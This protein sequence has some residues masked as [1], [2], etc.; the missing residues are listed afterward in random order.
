VRIAFIG[1]NHFANCARAL[2]EDGHDLTHFFSP[3]GRAAPSL[4]HLDDV[5]HRVR[6]KVRVGRVTRDDI[7]RAIN[8]G[9]EVLLSA[10]YPWRVPVDVDETI[11]A[12]N[13][14]PSPLPEGR[15]PA[16][17]EWAI[18]TGR[19]ATAVT[20]HQMLQ[21]F[22]AGP[23]LWQQPLA[24]APGE[25]VTSLR[26]RGAEL[27]ERGVR[28]V[29]G[30]F[31]RTW[32]ERQPQGPG[33]YCK[34]PR[35]VDRTLDWGSGHELLDRQLRAFPPGHRY[36]RI[37]ARDSRLADVVLWAQAH[38]YAPGSIVSRSGREYLIATSQGFASARIAAL[39]AEERLRRMG[40]PVVRR[41]WPRK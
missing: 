36:G 10:A 41:V 9:A 16:P 32:A 18:L 11:P 14:H 35:R 8:E 4:A 20:I 19:E 30:D 12:L 29:F 21:R 17:Y 40:W 6:K 34:T 24:L 2:I 15:G 26:F 27:A 3:G 37:G 39:G 1:S 13:I 25:S 38:G 33:T 22:D 31:D 7:D 28:E 23:M 5:A